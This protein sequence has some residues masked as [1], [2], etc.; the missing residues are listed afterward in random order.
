MELGLR[1]RVVMVTG[2]SSGVGLAT[3]ARLLEE[4]ASVATCARDEERLQA[5][6]GRLAGPDRLLSVRCDVTHEEEVGRFVGDTVARFGGV[7]GIVLNAGRARAGRFADTTDEDW[8]EELDLKFGSVVYPLRSALPALRRSDQPAVVLTN[9][10]LAR[11]P[12]PHLVATSAARAGVLNLARSLANELAGDGIRVN[13][14]LLGL[15]D[16][17]QWRRRFEQADPGVPYEEWAASIARERGVPLE[18][19]GTAEEVADMITVL[20]SPVSSY[21][22]GASLEVSGGVGRYV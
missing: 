2:G 8:R 12:E 11:Q 4:G 17:G 6:T 13:S 18:R 19:F 5:A 21:V 1:D 14:V 3:V 15:I 22:T 10:V 9:A 16:T 20:L 7:D